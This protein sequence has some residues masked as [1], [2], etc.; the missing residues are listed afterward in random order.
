MGHVSQLDLVRRVHFAS[1]KL[2]LNDRKQH[3]DDLEVCFQKSPSY[4]NV[5]Y[6]VVKFSTETGEMGLNKLFLLM[7]T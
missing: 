2:F 1:L 7:N 4:N 6:E 5:Y 3:S